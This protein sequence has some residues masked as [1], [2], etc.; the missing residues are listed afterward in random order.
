MTGSL[1]PWPSLRLADWKPTCETLHRWAQ[2]VGKIRLALA[3][4]QNHWWHVPLYPSARG[5]T[6]SAIPYRG[7]AL[8]L[9]FDLVR[10][11]LVVTT[12][13]GD[14]KR[15]ALLPRS[16]AAFHAE[17]LALLAAMGIEVHL[18]RMPVEIPNPIPFDED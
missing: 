1:D 12:S 3:P 10:H 13:D 14:E 15:L 9:A 7:G 4:P 18:W 11:D 8:E 2:M 5:L 17:L 6:T 16:V